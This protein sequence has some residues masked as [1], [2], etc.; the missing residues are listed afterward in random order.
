MSSASGIHILVF[1]YPAQG[2][3]LSLLDLTH[4]LCLR[5]LTITVLVTPKNLPTLSPLLSTHPSIQTLVLPLPPHP[6]L[7]QGV[8]NVRDIG[9][10]GNRPIIAALRQLHDP[11]I[12]WF[13]SH[14][15]PPVAIVSDFFLGWTLRLAHQLRIPRIAFFSSGAFLASVSDHCWR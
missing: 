9:N 13:H 7:P 1:P 3:M 10:A 12:R 4:Q 11:I 8:E 15:S 14:P 6:K 2:H 5:G